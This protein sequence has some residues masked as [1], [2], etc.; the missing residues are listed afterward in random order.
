MKKTEEKEE[1]R[2]SFLFRNLFKGLAWFAIIIVVFVL[3]EGYIQQNFKEHIDTIRAN[4]GILYGIYTISEIV[5]GILPP[6]IFMMIWILDNIDL[7]GFIINLTILTLISYAAG[8]LGYYIGKV[9]S[10]TKFYQER[11]REKYLKQYE[12]KLKTYGGYLVFVG[13]VTPVP[14]SATCMLAGSVN[15]NFKYF[16]LICITR[17]IRFAGYGAV[18]WYAPDLFKDLTSGF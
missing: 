4:P 11:I 8:I 16:L 9:F 2:S 5:F 3:L 17:V 1:T 6:E 18:V 12:G 13:A 14:F 15:L 7:S 10:K